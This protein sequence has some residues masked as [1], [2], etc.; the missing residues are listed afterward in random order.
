MENAFCKS[1]HKME[2]MMFLEFVIA[3]YEINTKRKSF[4]KTGPHQKTVLASKEIM[5]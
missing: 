5:Q 3:D 4:N 2:H 1:R